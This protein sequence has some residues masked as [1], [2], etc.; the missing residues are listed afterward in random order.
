[1]S[2]YIMDAICYMTPFPLM[3]WNWNLAYAEPIHVYHFQLW[4]ENVKYLFY[5]ICHYVVI[6]LHQNCV[7]LCTLS[8]FKANHGKPQGDCRLVH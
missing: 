5:E 7:W 2:T 6:P 8:Y 4:E 1:M 3:N